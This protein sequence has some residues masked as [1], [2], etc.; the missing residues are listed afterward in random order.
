M[1]NA[2]GRLQEIF[3]GRGLPLPRYEVKSLGGPPNS[4]VF[5]CTV[6]VRC[7][8]GRQLSEQVEVKGRK[9]EAEKLAA[10]KML[11]TLQRGKS[12]GRTPR[13][14]PSRGHSS[15]SPAPNHFPNQPAPA[16]TQSPHRSPSPSCSNGKSQVTVLQERLQA[17]HFSLPTYTETRQGPPLF[18]YRCQVQGGGRIPDLSTE[19]EGGS[20]RIAKDAAAEK[21]LKKMDGLTPEPPGMGKNFEHATSDPPMSVDDDVMAAKIAS[22]SPSYNYWK[23]PAEVYN[24]LRKKT[25]SKKKLF[26]LLYS[27]R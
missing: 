8:D 23:S 19:G 7:S 5:L 15:P 10:S 11:Q 22:L 4:P 16:S 12:S 1:D 14:S 13:T 18:R 24:E 9:K 3:Q 27:S 17:M 26:S 25:I 20:K 2:K 6:T 21:M